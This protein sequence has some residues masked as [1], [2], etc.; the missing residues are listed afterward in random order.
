MTT[1]PGNR[2]DARLFGIF[3]LIAFLSYGVGSA[4]VASVIGVPDVLV[5]VS[6]HK[7]Q[8]IVG[9][10]LMAVIHTFVN[11]GLPIIMLPILKP[12]N[13][14]L[15]Y[16]YL[17]AAIA[18][19]VVLVVGAISVLLLLPLS[20]AFLGAGPAATPSFGIMA[21][22]LSEGNF[23]AYQLGMVIWG[24]GGLMFGYLLYQSNLVP[25]FLPVWGVIGYVIFVSG[26]LLELF[27]FSVG[28]LLSIPGG[29][30]EI[31]LSLWLIVRGFRASPVVPTPSLRAVSS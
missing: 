26:N 13:R 9:A 23:Y 25:R 10:I 21:M 22:V 15:A 5:S 16:G 2:S 11:I 19:T 30:F 8:L 28:V 6:A 17:S 7:T 18:A 14:R 3:F 1:E 31:S 24:M 12:F 27:G 4:L 20:D 29:L